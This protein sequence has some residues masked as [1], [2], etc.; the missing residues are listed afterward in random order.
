MAVAENG[1]P[2]ESVKDRPN[3]HA[4]GPVVRRSRARR[5]S[6]TFWLFNNL[7]RYGVSSHY[8]YAPLTDL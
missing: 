4:V 7:A 1:R 6:W 5:Q 8:Q 2:I 3:G